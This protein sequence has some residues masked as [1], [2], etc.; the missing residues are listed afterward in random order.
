MEGEGT[1]KSGKKRGKKLLIPRL[2][3]AYPEPLTQATNPQ[4]RNTTP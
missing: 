3:S 2:N 1:G 4:S